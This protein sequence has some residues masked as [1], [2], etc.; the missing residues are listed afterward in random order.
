MALQGG[1]R[2]KVSMADVFPY[3]LY[4]M[5]VE[6]AEDYDSATRLRSPSRDKQT[7]ELV[8][9]V[10]CI[11]RDPEAR[12]KEVKVKVTAPVMPV[13]PEEVLPGSGLR[14]VDFS[15]LT[16]TPYIEEG[17]GGGRARMAYSIR[18]GGV[19]KQGQ[20]PDQPAAPTVRGN[21]EGGSSSS[22]KAA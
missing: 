17:R 7:G 10:T 3:G 12:K 20:A 4:A 5:G 22:A 1:H 16:I 11:D 9:T 2:F 19:H 13:L 21:S 15:G 14:A 8:W 18:A 6:Q